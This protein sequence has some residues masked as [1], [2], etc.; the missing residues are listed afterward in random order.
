ML[1]SQYLIKE[2]G[3]KHKNMIKEQQE[4]K[5][6][7]A[8]K[9]VH[10]LVEGN[11]RQDD[12]IDIDDMNLDIDINANEKK[13]KKKSKNQKSNMMDVDHFEIEE[14]TSKVRRNKKKRKSRS[15]F[16]VNY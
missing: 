1:P 8:L 3:K 12:I 15:H 10:D 2:K 6:N 7:L 11:F 9:Q 14:G 4:E 5:L 16:I 13:D